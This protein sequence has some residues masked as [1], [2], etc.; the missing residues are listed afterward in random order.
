MSTQQPQGWTEQV[1][2]QLD[3]ANPAESG[4]SVRHT[5]SVRS[6]D[7]PTSGPA[8]HRGASERVAAEGGAD[9]GYRP[10]NQVA[11]F[12]Q[13]PRSTHRRLSAR[14]ARTA[15]QR[16]LATARAL[17]VPDDRA[18]SL[19]EAISRVALPVATGRRI[20]VF[21]AHGGAGATTVALCLASLAATYRDDPV[22]L[23]DASA[24]HGGLLTR[25]R[26]APTMSV[27]AAA[28]HL[29]GS[30]QPPRA[31]L[32]GQGLHVFS[33]A[34]RS[35]TGQLLDEIQRRAGV[36][37]VDIAIA[38]PASVTNGDP[39]SAGLSAHAS[40][41]VAE[42]TVRGLA[43]VHECLNGLHHAEMAGGTPVVIFSERVASSGVGR[44][45]LEGGVSSAA[46]YHVFHVPPDRHL[47]GAAQ[48]R[49]DLLAPDT[50]LALTQIAATVIDASTR[51]SGSRHV[52]RREV[53]PGVESG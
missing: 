30:V 49:L 21:G 50:S 42:N 51:D 13:R 38:D 36:T 43:A 40:V 1:L 16:W 32:R 39:G 29:G 11:V 27:E 44:D 45:W 26:S 37:F 9:P 20:C 5:A 28:R 3:A 8:V 52:T 4:S 2:R 34:A 48:M 53:P 24:A 7:R 41:I 35:A 25:L 6:L 19:T 23:V 15:K 14:P 22:A 12:A 17:L 18:V 46:S 31:L 47:A 33:P 10:P